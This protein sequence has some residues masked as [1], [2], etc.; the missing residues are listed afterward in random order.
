[1]NQRYTVL[2]I[3]SKTSFSRVE[4]VEDMMTARHCII[5]WISKKA[6]NLYRHQFLLELDFLS[7]NQYP[8]FP[9]LY[10]VIEDSLETGIVITYF[11]GIRLDTWLT[12]EHSEKEKI[13]VFLQ[14]IHHI[15]QVHHQGYLY[16]DIKPQNFIMEGHTLYLIDFNALVPIGNTQVYFASKNNQAPELSNHEQKGIE[17]D[18]YGLGVLC[19]DFHM[20]KRYHRLIQRC[21]EKK[22]KHRIHSTKQLIRGIFIQRFYPFFLLMIVCV[23]LII[24]LLGTQD[25]PNPFTRY[26]NDP[27]P[28]TIV[29]AYQFT[30]QNI[31]GKKSQQRQMNLYQWIEKDWIEPKILVQPLVYEFFLQESILSENPIY[32]E[33]FLQYEK[34]VNTES[35][36]NTIL[37]AHQLVDEGSPLQDAWIQTMIDSFLKSGMRS[38]N[39]IDQ[40]D[41]FLVV[42]TKESRTLSI[43]QCEKLSQCFNMISKENFHHDLACHA[44]EYALIL[45]S[46]EQYTMTIPSSW[47]D[48]LK[49][50]HDFQNLYDLYKTTLP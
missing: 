13:Q 4:L 20:S 43:D 28:T 41:C 45:F 50:D 17:I 7:Q 3:F 18:I 31:E 36:L 37:L 38:P 22:V 8:Y 19:Q 39:K 25:D 9:S 33:Y 30:L 5:K 14:A 26:Q 27:S 15:S 6:P 2:R 32:V 46:Q 40:L 44:L 21:Q 47:Q 11:P 1:M 24:C 10:D 29:N 12:Q 34:K 23:P 35:I 49:N 42:L 16:I 48:Q